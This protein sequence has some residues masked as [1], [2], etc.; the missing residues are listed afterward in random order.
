MLNSVEADGQLSSQHVAEKIPSRTVT[1][2]LV[3]ER[4]VRYERLLN[5]F[6]PLTESL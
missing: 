4:E 3:P 6:R 1:L 5:Q 2:R